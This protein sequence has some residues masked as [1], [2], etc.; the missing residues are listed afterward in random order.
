[1]LLTGWSGFFGRRIAEALRRH[2]Y[3]VSIPGRPEF[4]LMDASMT[5][6]APAAGR[7]R[8]LDGLLATLPDAI[9]PCSAS[10]TILEGAT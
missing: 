1:V 2:G 10:L 6:R 5:C 3:D 9:P 4:D 7:G 8:A